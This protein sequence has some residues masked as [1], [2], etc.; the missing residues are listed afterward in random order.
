M[1]DTA[2]L[3]ARIARARGAVAQA[4]DGMMVPAELVVRQ[5]DDPQ[6]VGQKVNYY[7]HSDCDGVA[8]IDPDV[9][10]LIVLAVNAFTALLDVAEAT[11]EMRAA[12]GA[13]LINDRS[14]LDRIDDA[15]DALDAALA[16]LSEVMP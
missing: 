4:K 9:A 16:R 6:I 12:E 7:A 5:Y 14:T 3:A 11:R 8:S 10:P 15:T 2:D 1:T 13:A